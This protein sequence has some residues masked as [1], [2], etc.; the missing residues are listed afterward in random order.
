LFRRVLSALVLATTVVGTLAVQPAAADTSGTVFGALVA[1]QGRETFSGAVARQDRAYGA[2]PISRVFYNGA[3]MP[4]PDKAGASGRPVVVSF[5][6][7]PLEVID[8]R[9]DAAIRAFFR[10]APT[11]YDVF[12]SYIHEPEDNVIRGEFSAQDY[13]LAW[14]H[15]ADLAVAAAP[16]NPHLIS[17]LILMCYTM[18]PASGRNWLDFYVPAAQSMLAFDCY[19]HAGKRNRY[20]NPADIFRPV[21]DWSAGHPGIPWGI[22]EVGS[23]LATTDADGAKRA[24]WLHQVGAF[25]ADQ[26]RAAA[27]AA[28][29]GIYFDTVGPNGTDYRLTDAASQAAWR[30]VVQTY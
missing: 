13:R 11:T 3:L 24:A 2:M 29:F 18:N 14:Q 7:P 6:Y 30:E 27:R 19:N 28:V 17:A 5:K 16:G 25:L 9:H 23:T 1:T 8:G 15:V 22:S 21:T 12:W 20:G 4:W 10:D 26:H